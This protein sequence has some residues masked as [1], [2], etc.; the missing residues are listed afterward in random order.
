[1]A[2]R[3]ADAITPVATP[4]MVRAEIRQ[5][6]AEGRAPRS[7]PQRSS[8]VL[9]APAQPAYVPGPSAARTASSVP[10]LA[11]QQLQ[12][13]TGGPLVATGSPGASPLLPLPSLPLFDPAEERAAQEGRLDEHLA[14]RPSPLRVAGYVGAGVAAVALGVLTA[15]VLFDR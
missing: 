1:M 8:T 2:V 15:K 11:V 9:R 10:V 5:A 14:G 7:L 12:M 6:V 3:T 13:G 4:D